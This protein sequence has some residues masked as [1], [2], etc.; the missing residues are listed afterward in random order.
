MSENPKRFFEILI[1]LLKNGCKNIK[2]LL[3]FSLKLIQED[4]FK[5]NDCLTELQIRNLI[6]SLINCLNNPY[7]EVRRLA[8]ELLFIIDDEN[9]LLFIDKMIKDDNLWNKLKLLEILGGIKNSA[10]ERAIVKLAG[11]KEEMI[12]ERANFFL[13]HR[14]LLL[15]LQLI[16]SLKQ[17]TI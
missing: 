11:D 13:S 7:E 15:L 2:S 6:D 8:I 5:Y 4:E 9:A 1:A 10:A 12:S 3:E 17:E 16:P 14:I